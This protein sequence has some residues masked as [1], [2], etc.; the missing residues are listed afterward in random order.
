MLEEVK[1]MKFA[2]WGQDLL[3]GK[4]LSNNIRGLLALLAHSVAG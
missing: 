3:M 2:D 1:R 4:D